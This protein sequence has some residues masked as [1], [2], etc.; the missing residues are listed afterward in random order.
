MVNRSDVLCVVNHYFPHVLLQLIVI[1]FD[2]VDP[3]PNRMAYKSFSGA[4]GFPETL[5]EILVDDF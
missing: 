1:Q 3:P 2:T 5:P 4:G